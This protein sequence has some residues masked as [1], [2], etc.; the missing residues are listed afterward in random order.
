METFHIKCDGAPQVRPC[1][2]V[3]TCPW[4]KLFPEVGLRGRRG[5]N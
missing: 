1:R 4:G 5:E 2:L 3:A